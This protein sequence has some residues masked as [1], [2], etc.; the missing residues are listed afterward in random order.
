M[1]SPRS[2]ILGGRA[3]TAA[4]AEGDVLAADSADRS[5]TNVRPKRGV[6]EGLWLKCGG[7]LD[8]IFRKE[9]EAMLNV[10]P[11][12][13]HHWYVSAQQRVALRLSKGFWILL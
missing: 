8:T 12:C 11:K 3:G 2:S 10:C 13:G 9:A 6:P 7:C 5:P 4:A 1:E